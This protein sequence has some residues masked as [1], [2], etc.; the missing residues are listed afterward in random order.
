ME[1][2]LPSINAEFIPYFFDET[3]WAPIKFLDLSLRV[4]W[5]LRVGAN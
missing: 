5:T 2:I 4:F 3:T 1:Y